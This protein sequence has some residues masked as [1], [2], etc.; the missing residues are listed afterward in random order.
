MTGFW[1][2]VASAGPHANNRCR[3]AV[4]LWGGAGPP[5]AGVGLQV[6]RVMNPAVGCHYFPA[7]S[8]RYFYWFGLPG[9]GRL[10][11]SWML[12]KCK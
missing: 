12:L 9:G 5:D 11:L 1:D 10:Q 4:F 7:R 3:G 6:T 8:T 2:A